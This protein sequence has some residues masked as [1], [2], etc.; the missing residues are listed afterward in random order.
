MCTLHLGTT[1]KS[2]PLCC[3]VFLCWWTSFFF[4]FLLNSWRTSRIKLL[5][6]WCTDCSLELLHRQPDRFLLSSLF[7]NEHKVI[8]LCWERCS[9]WERCWL[10]WD[11]ISNQSITYQSWVNSPH[12]S[13]F[14]KL[15]SSEDFL[16][17][18]VPLVIGEL[19]GKTFEFFSS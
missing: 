4:S 19:Y 6:G 15:N 17:F 7:H 11:F 9:P 13:S 8:V 12:L 16:Q 18:V 2:I 10:L 1:F 14:L 5:R 3:I